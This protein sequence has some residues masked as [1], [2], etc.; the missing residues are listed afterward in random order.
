VCVRK[1]ARE[2]R[3]GRGSERETEEGWLV[4]A[5]H[6]RCVCVCVCVRARERKREKGRGSER[7]TVGE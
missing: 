6:V 3:R 5:I 1:R 4:Y 2:S 7:E